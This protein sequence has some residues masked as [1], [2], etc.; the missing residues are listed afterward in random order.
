MVNTLR[1]SVAILTAALLIGSQ[2]AGAQTVEEIQPQVLMY[3]LIE[4]EI[5]GDYPYLFVRPDNFA[6]QLELLNAA[7]YR[8]LYADEYAPQTDRTVILTFDDGYADNCTNLLPLLER[9]DACATIFLVTDAV[10]RPAHLSPEQ[11]TLLASSGRVRFGLHSASHV[12]LTTL[13]ETELRTELKYF[14]LFIRVWMNLT[15]VYHYISKRYARENLIEMYYDFVRVNQKALEKYGDLLLTEATAHL[16][17]EDKLHLCA[18]NDDVY[19]LITDCRRMYLTENSDEVIN[20]EA[21]T[22]V[23][24]FDPRVRKDSVDIETYERCFAMV[25]YSAKKR[26]IMVCP[27]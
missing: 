27:L 16:I 25:N 13:D 4:D 15:P 20:G 3:H 5:Y 21:V 1:S 6:A 8:Y 2:V 11:V 12:D 7:G 24:C 14:A 23:Y 17:R 19:D 10:G 26:D 18:E 9:Y 22:E